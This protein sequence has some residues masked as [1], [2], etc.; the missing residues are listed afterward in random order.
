M[1][2]QQ[3][4]VGQIVRVTWDG[5]GDSNPGRVVDIDRAKSAVKI[6]FS[7]VEPAEWFDRNTGKSKRKIYGVSAKALPLTR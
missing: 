3:V 1:S 4:M 5:G 6:E 7:P 2:L